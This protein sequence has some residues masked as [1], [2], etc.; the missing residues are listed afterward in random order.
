MPHSTLLVCYFSVLPALLRGVSLKLSK[1]PRRQSLSHP[2]RRRSP[3]DLWA[4]Y[5]GIQALYICLRHLETFAWIGGMSSYVP[6]A[7]KTCSD[8]LNDPLT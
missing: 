5:W 7:D 2:S 1:N 6:N 4:A 8:T 3:R